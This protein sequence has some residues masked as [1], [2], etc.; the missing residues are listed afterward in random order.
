MDVVSLPEADAYAKV[1]RRGTASTAP[2]LVARNVS[3]QVSGRPIGPLTFDLP[4]FDVARTIALRGPS[5][6][7]KTTLFR[8]LLRLHPRASGYVEIA[9]EPLSQPDREWLASSIAYVPQRPVL[10]WRRTIAENIAHATPGASREQI[11]EAARAACIHETIACLKGSYDACMPRGLSGGEQSRIALARVFLTAAPRLILADEPTT[12]IDRDTADLI[13]DAL[14]QFA[15]E[16]QAILLFT[17]HD[18]ALVQ[19]ADAIIDLPVMGMSSVVLSGT[20]GRTIRVA[21]PT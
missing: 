1:A 8:H 3:F 6:A 11:I 17:S 13:F 18:S 15:A 2:F 5:G 9:G 10:F 21:S 12:G 4:S 20:Q 19:K 14:R 16:K 7:G